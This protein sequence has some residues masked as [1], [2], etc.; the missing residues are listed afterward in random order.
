M[1]GGE[2]TGNSADHGGGIYAWGSAN[3]NIEGGKI[4]GNTAACG[5]GIRIRDHA[6]CHISGGEISG[7]APPMPVQAGAVVGL[8]YHG[9]AYM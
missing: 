1:T 2:I 6:V 9:P 3:I 8:L 7:N 4:T 5:G